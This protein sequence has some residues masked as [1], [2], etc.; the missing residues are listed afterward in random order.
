MTDRV[1]IVFLVHTLESGGAEG[2]L[3]EWLRALPPEEF[4]RRVIC[5]VRGGFHEDT[6]RALGVPIEVLGYRPMRRSNGSL[7]CLAAASWVPAFVRLV[8]SLR[9]FRPHILQTL[10]TMSDV[11]GALAVKLIRPQIRLAGSRLALTDCARLGR[12]R[13]TVMRWAV[14]RAD[15]LLCNSA[16]V[17]EDTVREQGADPKKITLVYNGVDCELF[18]KA[19][20]ERDRTRSDLGLSSG[21]QAIGS[22][23]Q[24]RPEKGHDTLLKAFAVLREQR[25]E[26]RLFLVGS[27]P[28]KD[29][30]CRRA[31]ELAIE[32]AVEF[33]DVRKDVAALLAAFD[34][35]VLPSQTE[36][37]SNV[38]LEGMA[39][40]VPLVATRVGGNAEALD[41]GRCGML[42]PP[43]DPEAMAKAM[44]GVLEN[45]EWARQTAEDAR[46]RA[47][48]LYSL[49]AL[50]RNMRSFY[51]KLA[52]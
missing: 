15:S 2:Q 22:V 16:A 17:A 25:P 4:D 51:R 21:D 37:F 6:V 7:D 8:R 40:G 28:K 26:S 38:V 13:Q 11:M 10:L 39:A 52:G 47:R 12:V 27:G 34:L 48:D 44:A 46:R 41:E 30:L 45:P 23:A 1:R 14:S 5:V 18:E 43:D 29:E 20:K 24:L 36:G 42:V 31:R 50:H 32:D 3:V 33:L 49:E 9:R 35:L 19:G